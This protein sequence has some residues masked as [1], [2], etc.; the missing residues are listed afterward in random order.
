[1]R[2]RCRGTLHSQYAFYI[3]FLNFQFDLSDVQDSRDI[4]GHP[5]SLRVYRSADPAATLARF[6]RQLPQVN[7]CGKRFPSSNMA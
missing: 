4:R 1:M 5:R 3:I 2:E 6:L 7:G